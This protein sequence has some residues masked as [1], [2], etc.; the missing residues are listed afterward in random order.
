MSVDGSAWSPGGATGPG[1]IRAMVPFAGHFIAVNFDG[2]IRQSPDLLSASM[3]H[4][5]VVRISGP[6][7]G[8][9]EIRAQ[10]ALQPGTSW[11]RVGEVN[12]QSVPLDWTDPEAD[13]HTDRWYR[14]EGPF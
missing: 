8:R 13:A 6:G 1:V 9:Y 2:S 11:P 7:G 12:L 4:P 14:V 3:A 5:G 10:D